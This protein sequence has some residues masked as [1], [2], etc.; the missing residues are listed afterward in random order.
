MAALIPSDNILKF[1]YRTMDIREGEIKRTLMMQLSIFLL[2]ATLLIIK[3]TINSMFLTN[4][5][6]ENL[7]FAFILVAV[8]AGILT[9]F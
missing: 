9:T 5:G 1:F 4:V 6:V 7:P 8:F 2:I 3:P